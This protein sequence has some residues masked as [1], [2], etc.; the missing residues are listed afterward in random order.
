MLGRVALRDIQ[1]PVG[2][3][4]NHDLPVFIPK[5]TLVV[6]SYYALHRNK[7][8]FGEDIETIEVGDEELPSG[9]MNLAKHEPEPTFNEELEFEEEQSL[10]PPPASVAKSSKLEKKSKRSRRPGPKHD[11]LIDVYDQDTGAGVPVKTG[12]NGDAFD[13]FEDEGLPL[14]QNSEFDF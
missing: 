10:T 2:G 14:G 11:D 1:L 3:G 12:R 7:S 8:V 5:D 4:P 13:G 6:M 9:S